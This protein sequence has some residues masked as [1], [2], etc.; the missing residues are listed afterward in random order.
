[1][2]RFEY[3]TIEVK[4]KGT[5]RSKFDLTEIDKT[6]NKYGMEGWELITV[7]DKNFGYG[8]TECFYFIF[9]REI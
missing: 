6:L 5:F 3:K 2:K 1:M 8:S 7:E 9:K 4:P